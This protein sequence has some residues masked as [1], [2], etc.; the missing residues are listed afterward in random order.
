MPEP[1]LVAQNLCKTFISRGRRV[2][3]LDDVSLTIAPGETLGLVGASGSGKSTLLRVL[4]GL[5][6]DYQGDC[7]VTTARKQ[8]VFVDQNPYLFRGTVLFNVMYGPVAGGLGHKAAART[9]TQW[10]ERLD[11]TKL[12]TAHIDR[13]S[14]GEKRRIALARAFAIEPE[15][16]LLDEPF[17]DLDLQG[18]ECVNQALAKL[19]QSTVLMTSPTSV[20]AN[21]A[22]TTCRLE[23]TI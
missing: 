18:I 16:L 14:G 6:H 5:E 22:A 3:A 17:A 8:R 7:R 1:V 2:T 19:P 9:A 12:A 23:R 11:I 20:P 13:L 21:V 15:L 10:L 4:A